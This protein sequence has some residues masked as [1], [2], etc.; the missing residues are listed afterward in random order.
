MS[1]PR[2]DGPLTGSEQITN[3]EWRYWMRT[4]IDYLEREMTRIHNCIEDRHQEMSVLIG[5]IGDRLKPLEQLRAMVLGAGVVILAL[6]PLLWWV[7]TKLVVV[8]EKGPKP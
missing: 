3:D 1:E 8:A 6:A 7:T 5:Q 2:R 4:K